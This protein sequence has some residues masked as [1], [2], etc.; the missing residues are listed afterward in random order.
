MYVKM[1]RKENFFHFLDSK[2]RIERK[3]VEVFTIVIKKTYG[4]SKENIGQEMKKH[5]L[6]FPL[7]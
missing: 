3:M 2:K 1:I 4:I 5:L 7:K 6:S